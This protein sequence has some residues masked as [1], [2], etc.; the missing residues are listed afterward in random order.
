MTIY[1]AILLCAAVVLVIFY[2]LAGKE[3]RRP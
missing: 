1:L 2:W 3:A